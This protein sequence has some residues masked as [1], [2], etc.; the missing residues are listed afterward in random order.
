MAHDGQVFS[1]EQ[2][3]NLYFDCIEVINN[4]IESFQMYSRHILNNPLS[5]SKYRTKQA[6]QASYYEGII[7]NIDVVHQMDQVHRIREGLPQV[8][9]PRYV[10]S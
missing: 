2:R 9:S 7:K 4:L 5:A 10:P 3:T 8:P 1:M 6:E